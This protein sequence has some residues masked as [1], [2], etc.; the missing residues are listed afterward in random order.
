MARRISA[1]PRT[2]RV[3][4]R[5]RMSASACRSRAPS[6]S[7]SSRPTRTAASAATVSGSTSTRPMSNSSATRRGSRRSRSCTAGCRAPSCRRSRSSACWSTTERRPLG[8]RPAAPIAPGKRNGLGY[9]CDVIAQPI[10]RRRAPARRNQVMRTALM[11]YGLASALAAA[12]ALL[13]PTAGAQQTAA[14]AA[15]IDDDDIGGVV[16]GSG[17]PEAG[18]WV[19]AETRPLPEPFIKIGVTDD[20]GRF[21][22]P[23]L[24]K[25]SYDVWVRGYGLVDSP[26]V[27]AEPG[28]LVELTAVPAPDAKA[29]AQVYPAIYWFSMLEIP[30]AKQFGPDN[31]ANIPE[32]IKQTDWLNVMKNNG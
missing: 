5:C 32:K 25:A 8:R 24:P 21:V 12:L 9:R 23:D 29:A 30:D 13:A 4:R 7:S 1:R 22:V 14:P 10:E 18:V 15:A 31:H 27:K 11:R 20:Q 6:A 28:K 16:R 2:S 26:K 3:S 19:I 17:G